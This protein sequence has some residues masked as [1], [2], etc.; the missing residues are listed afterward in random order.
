MVEFA[1]AVDAHGGL[2]EA[3][4]D[5]AFMDAFEGRAGE[6]AERMASVLY[7]GFCADEDWPASEQAMDAYVADVGEQT[8]E[9]GLL[10]SG[11]SM[12]DEV[13]E[14]ELSADDK[15]RFALGGEEAIRDPLA[16]EGLSDWARERQQNRIGL[17]RLA[18]DQSVEDESPMGP[19]TTIGGK[20][21]GDGPVEEVEVPRGFD[22]GE[23]FDFQDRR[24]DAARRAAE[25]ERTGIDNRTFDEVAR[26]VPAPGQQHTD[27]PVAADDAA[28]KLAARN[29]FREAIGMDPLSP[30]PSPR[31]PP[32]AEPAAESEVTTSATFPGELSPDSEY[33]QP[34]GDGWA[35]FSL[36]GSR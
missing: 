1:K 24:Q 6:G 19:V 26:G 33:R 29:A 9:L 17:E 23:E 35:T 27:V 20:S 25:R 34:K 36:P 12:K 5:A 11:L 14:S 10:A 18:R 30:P 2:R 3:L 7:K 16:D 15:Q 21:F 28:E 32:R 22:G 4:G 31:E 8:E 13:V